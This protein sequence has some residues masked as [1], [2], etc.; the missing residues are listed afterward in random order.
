MCRAAL[1]PVS[2][3][4]LVARHHG[5]DH[6]RV[7]L[8]ALGKQRTAGA[9]DQPA[10][11]DLFVAL[12]RLALEEA[13][14]NFAGSVRLFDVF[15]GEREEVEA[16]AF[17]AADRSDEHLALAVADENR[18]VRLLGEATGFER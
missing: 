12:A 11:E 7:A 3:V 2:R 9:I 18:A 13:A 6:L 5:R 10:G 15:A 8:V 4:D 14:R 1:A 16:G 17:V